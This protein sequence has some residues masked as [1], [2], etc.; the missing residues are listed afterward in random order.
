MDGKSNRRFRP[1]MAVFAQG[2]WKRLQRIGC[3]HFNTIYRSG[4]MRGKNLYVLAVLLIMAGPVLGGMV[5]YEFV[6]DQSTVLQHGGLFGVH[7]TY[8]I[9][10]RFVLSVD[11]GA[12]VASFDKVD[13]NLSEIGLSH[14]QDLNDLFNMTE[15]ACTVISDTQI[16]F[17][18]QTTESTPVDVNLMVTLAD[19]SVQI[20]GGTEPGCCDFF[21]Y[22]I[23]A[24]AVESARTIYVD[25]DAN[26]LNDGSSWT[27]AY[28][29]LQ[30][31]LADANT[32]A[33]P[34]EIHVAE[35]IYKP[36]HGQNQHLEDQYASFQLQNLVAI[37][38]G[39]GGIGEPDP[40]ARD[41]AAYETI[42]SGEISDDE[43]S[44][45]VVTGSGTDRTAVLDGFTITEG[46]A[47]TVS[48]NNDLGG[49]MYC[50][51]GHP[52]IRNC[53]F[54]NNKA[55]NYGGGMCN[56]GNSCP[57]L[58]NCLFVQNSATDGGGMDNEYSHP[59]LINCVFAGNWVDEYN[60][61]S[62][63]GGAIYNYFSSPALIN[64]TITANA[65]KQW[66]GCGGIYNSTTSRPTLT[67]C[68]LSENSDILGKIESSQIA[69]G[70]PSINYSC[71]QGLTG[72]LGGISNIG[73]D[74]CFA[75]PSL[76]E[77]PCGT[78]EKPWD[79]VWIEG[80]YHLKSQ[81]GRWDANSQS[82]VQDDVTSPCIDAGD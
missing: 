68:I 58:T 67:N 75:K 56:D 1:V 28:N 51:A 64:C 78:P 2:T 4:K 30:D 82:W 6:E 16:H 43:D 24:V 8:S 63:S 49:G 77:D 73:D 21:I 53:T 80:D 12:G 69:G 31:A 45:H 9:A 44:C 40:N 71:V 18:G 11:F 76:W 59:I 66:G 54:F 25:A 36:D 33:K 62:F 81:A 17:V 65:A 60:A 13:A 20:T 14:T 50:Y 23:D 5:R 39:Y 32:S 74:P 72:D 19:G 22:N 37:K 79:D 34:I 46:Q 55:L 10:G 42:L 47:Y 15:L 29:Y 52:T 3:N 38:G 27:N 70:T 35:G 26:G 41:I 48:N 57:L 61:D 7:I